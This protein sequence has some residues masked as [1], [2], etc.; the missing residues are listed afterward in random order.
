MLAPPVAQVCRTTSPMEDSDLA[1]ALHR[2]AAICRAHGSPLYGSL[3]EACSAD[4]RRGGAVARALAECRGPALRDALPLRLMAAVHALVLDGRAPELAAF[5]PSAAG[6][7]VRGSAPG[8]RA[9][10]DRASGDRASGDA[11]WPAFERLVARETDAIAT[12]VRRVPQTNEVGRSG[13]LLGGFLEIAAETALPQRLCELG[14][15]AGLNLR[16]DRYRHR[17][18]ARDGAQRHAWGPTDARVVLDTTWNGGPPR[19]DAPLRVA[20]RT[21][22]DLRPVDLRDPA[23]CLTLESYVWADQLERLTLLR[24]A[25]ADARSADAASSPRI[26]R[27]RAAA[28]LEVQLAAPV[29]GVATVV[30]HS[31]VWAYLSDAE[32]ST[33]ADCIT[34]AGARAERDAPLAWLRLE[35]AGPEKDLLLQVWPGGE[36]RRLARADPHGRVV[37]WL[38]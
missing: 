21:G 26:D 9:P 17:H 5:Y 34:A 3:L 38:G 36:L 19:L 30:F 6:G 2:Q 32:Q 37:D 8:D 31:V 35:E 15:S 24:A 29:R 4:V 10:G 22:C 14:S 27:A 1:D 7:G 18:L 25:I 13:A 33:V 12:A 28:W 11:A 20:A 16:F 23:E